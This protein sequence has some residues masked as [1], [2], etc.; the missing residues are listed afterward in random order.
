[1]KKGF[2]L[3]TLAS[4]G[5]WIGG[6]GAVAKFTEM[7]YEACIN[8]RAEAWELAIQV[9]QFGVNL[10]QRTTISKVMIGGVILVLKVVVLVG[11]VAGLIQ[12]TVVI[13]EWSVYH[14]DG[15]YGL[16]RLLRGSKI[17]C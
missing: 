15:Y 3:Q 7:I 5:M 2:V 8:R 17:L 16:G 1:M 13:Y 10:L 14:R 12:M 4:W 9:G 6:L 11:A